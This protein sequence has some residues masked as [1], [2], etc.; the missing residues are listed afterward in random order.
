MQKIQLSEIDSFEVQKENPNYALDFWDELSVIDCFKLKF[1][2]YGAGTLPIPTFHRQ[3]YLQ[4]VSEADVAQFQYPNFRGSPTL[5]ESIARNMRRFYHRDI[6]PSEDVIV[7]D[8]ANK[9]TTA[10]IEANCGD[11]EEVLMFEPYY[12]DHIQFMNKFK[13]YR[14][15]L[16]QFDVIKNEDGEGQY[17]FNIENFKKA[18]KESVKVV[19]IINPHNPGT[20]VF[21]HEDMELISEVLK[22]YPETIVIE[23]NVY[24]P[25]LMP[26]SVVPGHFSAIGNNC[27]KT[28]NVF[29][30]GKLF[31]CHGM[32]V[33]WAISCKKMIDKVEKVRSQ[34]FNFVSSIEQLIAAKSLDDMNRKYSGF[35]DYLEY[36][37]VTNTEKIEKIGQILKKYDITPLKTMGTYYINA[38]ISN[39][40]HKIPEEYYIN[41]LT[42]ERNP[43]PDKAF[44]RWLL[45]HEIGFMPHTA[46]SKNFGKYQNFVRIAANRTDEDINMV[47]ETLDSML[48]I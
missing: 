32:R 22:N 3:N 16:C 36:L 43:N 25:F 6:K 20:Y 19:I 46:T 40:V 5:L 34:N 33:G 44:C 14:V 24:F 48:C 42:G 10:I 18:M 26:D 47:D 28:Y 4:I 2:P 9:I 23:E 12:A 30:G 35:K 21:S 27:G 37:K 38:D 17:F 45:K 7:C 13:N 31:N 41:I 29:S 8:G 15:R 11:G 39:I 1:S